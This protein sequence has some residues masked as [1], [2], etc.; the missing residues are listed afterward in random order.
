MKLLLLLSL[1]SAAMAQEPSEPPVLSPLPTVKVDPQRVT[2]SGVSSGAFFAIQFQVA[3]SNLVRGVAP[4]AGGSYW[5]A[6]GSPNKAQAECMF[7]SS[8][9]NPKRGVEKAKEEANA[10]KIDPLENLSQAKILIFSG[11]K[12]IVIHP[13]HS[14]HIE[15]FFTSF[16]PKA[17]IL[18]LSHPEAPHGFPTDGK[19]KACSHKGVPWINDCKLDLAG[20][21]LK[22]LDSGQ[23]IEAAK[24][25][26]T[27]Y[28]SQKPYQTTSNQLYDWG[29]LYIPSRCASE[30]CGLH[31]A[32]HGCQMNADFIGKQ[33]IELAG[34][35]KWADQKGIILAFP[36]IAKGSGNPQGCWDWFGYTDPKNYANKNGP[37]MM[38]IRRIVKDLTGL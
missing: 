8:R 36:Q 3:H 24:P 22:Y 21:I 28:F 9:A 4:V 13:G 26:T 20:E 2:V 15:N 27:S 16:T 30:S 25:G 35:Q 17:Q 29:A 19:G 1:L 5:C 12:D 38:A 23:A 32:F 11:A 34:Y 18:R 31:I 10:G 33:F 6:E 37:Q 7:T 14:E